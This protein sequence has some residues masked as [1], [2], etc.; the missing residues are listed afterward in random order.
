MEALVR[1]A[2]ASKFDEEE[3]RLRSMDNLFV[4][5]GI[6]LELIVDFADEM[7]DL[8]RKLGQSVRAADGAADGLLLEA[9]N[10][11]SISLSIITYVKVKMIDQKKRPPPALS[12]R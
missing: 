4:H 7:F 6:N 10:D 5:V 3:A 1:E 12:V 8:L 2:N 11:V 9:F